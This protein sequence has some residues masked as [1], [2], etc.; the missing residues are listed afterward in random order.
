MSFN[1]LIAAH[2]LTPSLTLTNSISGST[3]VS[4]A[5]SSTGATAYTIVWPNAA[6]TIDQALAVASVSGPLVNL[7]WTGGDLAPTKPTVRI[8]PVPSVAII[9]KK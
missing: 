9:E 6:G 2:T 4:M 7:A 5:S 1:N 8:A 3:P